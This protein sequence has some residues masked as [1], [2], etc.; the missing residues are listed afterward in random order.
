MVE[1]QF[2]RLTE[3]Q[4]TPKSTK[5][6][7]Y[8]WWMIFSPFIWRRLQL[9]YKNIPPGAGNAEAISLQSRSRQF[10]T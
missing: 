1:P 2:A 3:T 4:A 5:K 10:Y 6:K 7:R 9:P 8:R